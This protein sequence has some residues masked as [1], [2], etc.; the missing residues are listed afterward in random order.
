VDMDQ[1]TTMIRYPFV[2]TRGKCLL[3]I[4]VQVNSDSLIAAFVVSGVRGLSFP[5]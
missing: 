3:N 4:F 1:K 2:A 5:R